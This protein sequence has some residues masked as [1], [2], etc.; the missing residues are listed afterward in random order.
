[1]QNCETTDEDKGFK[2]H[3][4]YEFLLPEVTLPM[5]DIKDLLYDEQFVEELDI[6][7]VMGQE[8]KDE[9]IYRIV[10]EMLFP[11]LK[12]KRIRETRTKLFYRKLCRFS[13]ILFDDE[14]SWEGD[15]QKYLSEM[16]ADDR[17]EYLNLKIIKNI[18]G[19]KYG[20]LFK[21]T[22]LRKSRLNQLI[23]TD[24]FI[25]AADDIVRSGRA[26][27]DIDIYNIAKSL[28]F[29]MYKEHLTEGFKEDYKSKFGSAA[30]K[31]WSYRY[32]VFGQSTK[33]FSVDLF[34]TEEHWKSE[35]EDY[36]E[37]S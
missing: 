13:K 19:R 27:E 18:C 9:D 20:Y 10:E 17:S 14:Y 24:D 8:I 37:Q 4:E 12:P 22:A 11:N 34:G 35:F 36:L 30:Y 31:G 2:I 23:E 29:P 32:R 21:T 15:Y 5:S 7:V 28:F 33:T 3:E 16:D 25:K 1:M 6:M 26:I